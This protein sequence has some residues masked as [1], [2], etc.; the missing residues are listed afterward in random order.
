MC[1]YVYI[2]TYVCI[3]YVCLCM[4]VSV[5]VCV[6]IYTGWCVIPL[7]PFVNRKALGIDG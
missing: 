1:M 3:M 7:P 4:Y 5:C 6:Y 2:R